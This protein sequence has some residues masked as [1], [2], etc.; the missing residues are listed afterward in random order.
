MPATIRYNN[1]FYLF[2]E[3]HRD[4]DVYSLS[5]KKEPTGMSREDYHDAL[6]QI[7]CRRKCRNKL[8]TFVSSGRFLFPDSLSAEQSSDEIVASFH[9]SLV[10][11]EGRILDMTAGLGID[12]MTISKNVSEVTALEIDKRKSLFLAHNSAELGIENLTV[13]NVDCI[14]YLKGSSTNYDVIFIDPAR[15][16]KDSSRA[17]GFGDSQ[18]DIVC[19]QEL[20]M[21]HTNRLLVKSSPMLD[22]K[23]TIREFPGLYTLYIIGL[24]GECKEI[25]LEIGRSRSSLKIVALDLSEGTGYEI[26]ESDLWNSVGVRFVDISEVLSGKFLYEPNPSLMKCGCWKS[27]CQRYEGLRKLSPNTHL[28]IHDL[29][30]PDFPGRQLQIEKELTKQEFK[31]MKGEKINVATRNYICKPEELKR[32]HGLK[33]GGKDFI[34]G[35]K[36]GGC[37]KPILM[38]CSRII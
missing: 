16:K 4:D 18:P 1:D 9:G 20:I 15:R 29:H 11:G 31:L 13:K 33:D 24:R 10:A 38:K 2:V 14:E 12:A 32:R 26:E 27:L 21:S 25:L 36:K 19:N 28:F 8:G 23:E 37:E 7:E 22:I 17:Y 5:M 35:A 3:N 34:Y 6:V 30:I